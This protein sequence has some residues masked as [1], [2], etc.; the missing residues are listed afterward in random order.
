M[1]VIDHSSL[2]WLH[3]LKNSTGRLARWA[4]ELLEYDYEI[5]HRKGALHYGCSVESDIKVKGMVA[6]QRDL[7]VNTADKWYHKRFAEIADK[8]KRYGR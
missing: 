6:V 4:L 7:A 1:I 5:V 3:N 8:S 2:C